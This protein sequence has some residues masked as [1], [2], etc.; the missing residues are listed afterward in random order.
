VKLYPSDKNSKEYF[1]K[2]YD[3][4]KKYQS[5]NLQKADSM[6]IVLLNLCNK[7]GN[8]EIFYALIFDADIDKIHGDKDVYFRKIL[9]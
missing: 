3:L 8:Y 6:R 7:H 9:Q 5:S 2:M 4:G 1:W